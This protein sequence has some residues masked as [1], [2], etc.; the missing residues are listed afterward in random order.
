MNSIYDLMSEM[1]LSK[2]AKKDKLEMIEKKF[3][4]VLPKQHIDFMLLHNG[5]EGNIGKYGYLAIWSVS[6]II[7]FNSN[8]T[9]KEYLPE[10]F[11]FASDRSG[12][13]FAYD[14]EDSSMRIVQV[15]D[16]AIDIEDIEYI[17]SSFN[18]FIEFNYNWI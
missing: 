16:E 17:A 5:G 4:I 18:E 10:L 14:M 9:H 15:S 6:E 7:Q 12:M 2:P 13:L 11:F 1:E 3:N 8:S